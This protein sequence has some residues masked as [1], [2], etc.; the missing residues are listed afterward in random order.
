MR[1]L[2]AD[3]IADL[4]AECGSEAEARETALSLMREAAA[5]GFDRGDGDLHRRV[6]DRL[7]AEAAWRAD[8]RAKRR[9]Q[10]AADAVRELRPPPTPPLNSRAD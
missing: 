9:L 10:A 6:C 2:F 8:E 5:A 1:N 7:G 3:T 4:V